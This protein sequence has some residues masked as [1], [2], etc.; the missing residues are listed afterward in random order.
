M[1]FYKN[2]SPL[3]KWIVLLIVSVSLLILRTQ[4]IKAQE[5]TTTTSGFSSEYVE[6]SSLL[7]QATDSRNSVRKSEKE[8]LLLR[9]AELYTK[10]LEKSPKLSS[11]YIN[12]GTAYHELEEYEKAI[13]DYNSAL[14][15]SPNSVDALKNRGLSYEKQG[16]MVEALADFELFLNWIA[17]MPTERRAWEREFFGKKVQ[18]L[19]SENSGLEEGSKTEKSRTLDNNSLPWYPGTWG[20]NAVAHNRTNRNTGQ[21]Q[22]NLPGFDCEGY[23][24]NWG[25]NIENA[26]WFSLPSITANRQPWYLVDNTIWATISADHYYAAATGWT[27]VPGNNYFLQVSNALYCS[28][29][30]QAVPWL[31]RMT[32]QFWVS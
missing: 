9:A 17:D 26:T 24:W 30:H 31:Y 25:Y 2:L 3:S 22:T 28:G 12:R 19:R 15:I 8:E 16:K 23:P 14:D 7:K 18:K 20:G 5:E 27:P 29:V 13:V 11:A 32:G 21:T 4:L 10:A 1:A 6:A